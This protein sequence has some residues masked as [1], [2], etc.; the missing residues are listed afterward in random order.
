MKERWRKFLL[1]AFGEDPALC[2]MYPGL[3]N[4]PWAM[5]SNAGK[6]AAY[7]GIQPSVEDLERFLAQLLQRE[8]T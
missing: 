8:N 7:Y 1:W 5:R 3:P 2:A 6:R 4:P